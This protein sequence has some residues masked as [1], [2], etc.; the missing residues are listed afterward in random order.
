M[1]STL[2]DELISINAIYGQNTLELVEADGRICTLRLPNHSSYVLRLEFPENYPDATPSVLGTESVGTNAAKGAGKRTIDV[3]REILASVYRPGEPCIFDLIEAV[4]SEL[5]SEDSVG[6]S[7][8]TQG[9]K[10]NEAR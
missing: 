9:V 1:E 2:D 8:T 3:C 10:T 7:I 5:Q 4:N 6:D